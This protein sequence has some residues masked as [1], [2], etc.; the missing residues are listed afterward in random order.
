MK[1]L[2]LIQARC[3]SSRL[4]NKVLMDLAG[5]PA[6]LR[7]IER[8]QKSKYVDEVI[9]VTSINIENLAIVKLCA[10]YGVRVFPGSED[11]VLDR[12]YQAAKLIKPEYIIRVTGDCPLYDAAL[13]DGAIEQMKPDTDYIAQL[14][15]E[16][17][18]DGLDI[19]VFTREALEISW[20]EAVLKSE[21][22]HV[23][24]YIRKHGERFK[25]QDL[26]FPYGDYGGDRWTLDELEDYELISAIYEHFKNNKDFTTEDVL[27][28]LNGDGAHLRQINN[29]IERNEGLKKSI[30]NDRVVL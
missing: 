4:P 15:H 21:R 29:N 18:P 1:Y 8:V 17:Y 6:L 9:V 2:A 16:T 3:G 7:T 20:Q 23:T 27:E 11:D 25:L 22:E 26:L 28:F 24:Q 14:G 5:K 12:F 10:D 19:E 30:L 13:L